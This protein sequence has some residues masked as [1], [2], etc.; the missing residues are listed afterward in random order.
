MTEI[1]EEPNG[2]VETLVLVDEDG[3]EESFYVHDVTEFDSDTY[4]VLENQA[5]AND[6]RILKQDGDQLVSLEDE[7]LDRVIKHLEDDWAEE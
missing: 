6:V 2:E 1:I 7:E 5:D 3:R 4:F